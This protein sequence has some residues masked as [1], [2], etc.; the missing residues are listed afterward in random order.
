MKAACLLTDSIYSL[1]VSDSDG[2]G[3]ETGTLGRRFAG[4]GEVVGGDGTAGEGSTG[5]G[6]VSELSIGIGA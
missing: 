2:I 6:D 1:A 5:R 4:V 3:F